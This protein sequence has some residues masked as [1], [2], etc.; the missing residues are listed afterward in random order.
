MP[1]SDREVG[2]LVHITGLPFDDLKEVYLPRLDVA[3]EP[4]VRADIAEYVLNQNKYV[5][6]EGGQRGTIIDPNSLR[7]LIRKRIFDHLQIRTGV[8]PGLNSLQLGT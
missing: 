3:Q 6:I 1:L 4:L 2:Q 7:L 5:K 8:S